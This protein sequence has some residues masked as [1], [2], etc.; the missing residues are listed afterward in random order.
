M[1]VYLCGMLQL[2]FSMPFPVGSYL[3]ECVMFQEQFSALKM[4]F[5]ENYRV[6]FLSGGLHSHCIHCRSTGLHRK[7]SLGLRQVQNRTRGHVGHV[8]VIKVNCF[9][10]QTVKFLKEYSTKF[11]VCLC[12][13]CPC[14][15]VKRF[16]RLDTVS[17]DILIKVKCPFKLSVICWSSFSVVHK[18]QCVLHRGFYWDV[19]A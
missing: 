18:N 17:Y 10:I 14:S 13:W 3:A 2:A 12:I 1:H 19:S 5:R 7:G 11:K 16:L 15:N 8:H 6:I 9:L 4:F